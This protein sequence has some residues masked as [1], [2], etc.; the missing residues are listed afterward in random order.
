MKCLHTLEK[1]QEKRYINEE[2]DVV[3]IVQIILVWNMF[4]KKKVTL[5]LD[6]DGVFNSLGRIEDP[7]IVIKQIKKYLFC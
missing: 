2:A 3:E 5:L 6:I 4:F 7:I 1:K